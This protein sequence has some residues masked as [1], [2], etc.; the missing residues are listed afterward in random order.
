LRLCGRARTSV[1]ESWESDGSI[2]V[3]LPFDDQHAKPKPIVTMDER[4][5][6]FDEDVEAGI[7]APSSIP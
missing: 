1:Q 6:R 5:L 3:S 7:T 2:L 4:N